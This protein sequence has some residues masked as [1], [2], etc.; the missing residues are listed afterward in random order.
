MNKVLFYSI[1]F[2]AYIYCLC[3]CG[4][5]PKHLA[6]AVKMDSLYVA[7]E[8]RNLFPCVDTKRGKSDSTEYKKY[9]AEL[10]KIQDYYNSRKPTHTTD[11][12]EIAWTDSA[13]VIALQEA[14][15]G[16]NLTIATQEAYIEDLLKICKDKPPI[17]DT[18]R[19]EDSAKIFQMR[20]EQGF[21]EVELNKRETKIADQEKEIAT[22]QGK[23][24]KKNSRIRW[25]LLIII[26]L[27]GWTLRKPILR[28]I[29]PI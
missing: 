15:V 8:T 3:S 1:L 4:S 27:I 24:K 20:T 2:G 5:A 16:R 12:L 21:L 9:Q 18:V 14:L 26:A 6:K 22:L 29:K 11:T 25:D 17:R 13:K 28:L 7:K 10:Q 19:I 23:V